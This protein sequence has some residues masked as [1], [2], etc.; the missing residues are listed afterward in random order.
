MSYF[1]WVCWIVPDN[2]VINQL[3]G[4]SSGLVG[5]LLSVYAL[6]GTLILCLGHVT[7]HLRLGPDFVYWFPAR[8]A[9]VG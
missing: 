8:D 5:I 9:L 4:Y 2:V 7:T 6:P 1:N 3:F